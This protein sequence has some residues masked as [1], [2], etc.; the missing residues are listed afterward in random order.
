M[1]TPGGHCEEC[2]VE[3]RTAS[4]GRPKRFCGQTCR[5]RASRRPKFPAEMAERLTWVRCAGKRP[6]MVDG[7]SA[8]TTDPGTWASFSDVQSGAGDG[9]GVMLG[10]GLGCYDLDHVTDESAARFIG[11]VPEP[12]LFCERSVSGEGVH[13]FVLMPESRC[14]VLRRADGSRVERYS[15]GRFIRTTGIEFKA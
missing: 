14:S 12:V 6:L 9:F 15:F 3:L 2:G 13:V 10:N 11:S 4:T 1:M 5:K 7:K 8:S